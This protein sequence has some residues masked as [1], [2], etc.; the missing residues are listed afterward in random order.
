MVESRIKCAADQVPEELALRYLRFHLRYL[1]K[2][3][4]E[5]DKVGRRSRMEYSRKRFISGDGDGC[6]S[7]WFQRQGFGAPPDFDEL[8]WV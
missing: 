5:L 8:F 3:A 4:A 1:K 2:S 7:V 6:L